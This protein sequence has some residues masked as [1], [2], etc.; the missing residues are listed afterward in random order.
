[1]KERDSIRLS[2]SHPRPSWEECPDPSA[3]PSQLGARE[4]L[5]T[6]VAPVARSST[7]KEW[8]AAT[9]HVPQHRAKSSV[10]V[11]QGLSNACSIS[12]LEEGQVQLQGEPVLPAWPCTADICT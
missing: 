7:V 9:G 1:M 5:Q 11:P 3:S 2:H 12:P 10:P 8:R 6:E 4:G